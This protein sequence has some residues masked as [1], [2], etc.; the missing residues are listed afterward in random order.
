VT[1]RRSAGGVFEIRVD[2]GLK[3]SK[4]PSGEFPTSREILATVR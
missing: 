2:G 3:F 4:K 1:L